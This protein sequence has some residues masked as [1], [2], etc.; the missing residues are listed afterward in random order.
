MS[1]KNRD[2]P[3][4]YYPGEILTEREAEINRKMFLFRVTCM[5]VALTP[6]VSVMFP[7]LPTAINRI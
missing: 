3:L 7:P 4:E 1:R 5:G 6:N 2:F